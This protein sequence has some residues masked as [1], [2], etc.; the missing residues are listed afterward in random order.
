M[1]RT[2][3]YGLFDLDGAPP[4]PQAAT[5]L[6]FA[7]GEPGTPLVAAVDLA[8]PDAATC[9]HAGGALTLFLGRLDE[10]AA[11]A[12]WLGMATGTPH[13]ALA[14]AAFAR[15]GPGIRTRL[16]GEWT[17]ARWDG[18]ALVL[19]AS[20]AQRDPLLYAVRGSRI[21]IGPDLRQLSRIA[22]IDA[23]F[24][25]AGLLMA[26]GRSTLRAPGD[27]RTPI[28]GVAALLPGACLTINRHGIHREPPAMIETAPD[29]RGTLDTA[30]TEAE[31]LMQRIVRQRM[32][33]GGYA[34]MVSGGLDSA[35]LAW[36]TAKVLAPGER[37]RFLTSAAQPGSQQIDEMAEAAI[38][39]THL[40]I[41]HDAVIADAVP[42]PYRPDPLLFRDANGPSLSV[43]HYLYHRFAAQTRAHDAAIL[44]DGQFGELI[45]SNSL[46]LRARSAWWRK[47][48][49]L[50]PAPR[51]APAEAFHVYLARHCLDALPEPL[52]DALRHPH[53][54]MRM[55][56]RADRWGISPG[57]SKAMR[58]PASLDLGRVRVAMPFRDPRLVAL[59]AGFPAAMLYPRPGER[60]AA[61][62]LLVGKLPDAIR[63]RGKGPGFAPDYPD[64]LRSEAEAA[65]ER[66]AL[67]RRA[68]ADE[69]LDLDVLDSGLARAARGASTS[70][71][72][73]TRTQ[74]TALAGEFIAWWRGAS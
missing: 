43:R 36:L 63:L 58:A 7:P 44:F 32:V 57:F 55:P 12:E 41:P 27:A 10:P 1:D 19:I 20:I 26:L 65:R 40:G 52:R 59:F 67:F 37:L 68:G 8:D 45:F 46:P 30:M 31:A 4:D 62:H 17:F 6:G 71:D 74:L 47:A 56:A 69:W 70:Y 61:R 51:P 72:E 73:A 38:I 35:T 22:W 5:A 3:L 21:A 66:I 50:L 15:S 54:P 28:A 48:R 24:D 29:W 23:D 53:Q 13:A 2:G 64:R 11:V 42:G 33:G 34:C 25:P 14:E 60:T 16:H 49:R 9:A 18:R 39:A